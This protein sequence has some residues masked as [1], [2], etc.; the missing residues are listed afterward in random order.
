[1]GA[2]YAVVSSLSYFLALNRDDFSI[3]SSLLRDSSENMLTNIHRLSTKV[4]R[5]S[6]IGV[7]DLRITPPFRNVSPKSRISFTI[8]IDF[9][10]L[11]RVRYTD[12]GSPIMRPHEDSDD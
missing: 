10:F 4:L 3:L 2:P 5:D 7:T 11:G 1:M 8:S 12:L 6:Q 9:L